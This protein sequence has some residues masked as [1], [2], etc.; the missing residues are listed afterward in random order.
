M[1]KTLL[2]L[3]GFIKLWLATIASGLGS[4]FG[5][6]ILSW[7]VYEIS[8]SK[9]A[10][11]TVWVFYLVPGL[12]V[13]LLGGPFIDRWNKKL[14]MIVSEW[15]RAIIFLIPA[16]LYPFGM[17]ELWHFYIL[18]VF[19]GLSEPLFRP[20][21]MAYIPEI[22][23]KELLMK[24]NSLLDGTAQIMFLIGPVLG[25]LLV[26]SF[27]PSIVLTILVSCLSL[28]GVVLFFLPKY[29]G[30]QKEKQKKKSWWADFKEGLG[31]YR[32]YP[33]LFFVGMMMMMVNFSSGAAQPM[34]LPYISEEFQGSAFQ[35]GLFTSFFSVGMI[36]GSL[37]T[38]LLPEP[39]NRKRVMLGSIFLTG[40]S[41][42][43]L[44]ISPYYILALISSFFSG[45]FAI[46]FNINNTTLY[47][48]WVPQE[49]RGRVFAVRILLAQAGVPVG[50]AVGGIVAEIMGVRILFGMLGG[51]IMII[52][53]I[54]YLIPIFSKLN[55]QE[56]V[57]E[58]KEEQADISIKSTEQ[59]LST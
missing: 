56:I 35:Y 53:T 8:G 19:L 37:L 47:Q 41:T 58:A 51:L 15:A 34:F 57:E 20:A 52:A 38:G 2:K 10:M 3:P 14:I 42:L 7:L 5:V 29:Q 16:I 12:V 30:E 33:V 31:F 59:S 39:K 45:M 24:A 44:A 50:A 27:G 17:L 13:Q 28:A 25:G 48:R 22:T 11:G 23:P 21:F 1:I 18:V 4:T 54:C 49:L 32:M 40:V 9:L 6:F 36:A 26:A 55:Q 43:L 46:V